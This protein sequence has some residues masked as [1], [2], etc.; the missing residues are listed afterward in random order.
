MGSRR[1][2]RRSHAEEEGLTAARA[3]ALSALALA[4]LLTGY[5]LLFRGSGGQEYTLVFQNAGQ[6]VKDDDVQVAGRRVG[7]V[8]SIELTGDNQAAVKVKVQEPYAPLHEGTRAV[9]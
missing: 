9:V 3:I 4:V 1:R 5:L 6:L 8:R 2:R 7:S